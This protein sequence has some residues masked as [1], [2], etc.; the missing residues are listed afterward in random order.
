MLGD[1]L[2]KIGEQE[3][4]SREH[5]IDLFLGCGLCAKITLLRSTWKPPISGRLPQPP[6]AGNANYPDS[7]LDIGLANSNYT[8]L[9]VSS[10][11]FVSFSSFSNKNFQHKL[12]CIV[13]VSSVYARNL[14]D[15]T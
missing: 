15:R 2:L 14:V 13:S 1:R 5:V 11:R 3:I 9:P 7:T 8:H 6:A 4:T 10:V 12:K